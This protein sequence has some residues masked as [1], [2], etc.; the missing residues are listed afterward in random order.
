MADVTGCGS[1]TKGIHDAVFR[2]LLGLED[3]ADVSGV[4]ADFNAYLSSTPARDWRRV[5]DRFAARR[6]VTHRPPPTREDP[7]ARREAARRSL[8]TRPEGT[9]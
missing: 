1:L 7:A 9:I 5:W 2:M 4:P 8:D 3:G 6:K